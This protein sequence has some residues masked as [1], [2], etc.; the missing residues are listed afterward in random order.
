MPQQHQ[1][2]ERHWQLLVHPQ[3]QELQ[4]PVQRS[5]LLLQR[6]VTRL[7]GAMEAQDWRAQEAS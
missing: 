4:L 2:E 1:Q 5:Q 7:Q 3:S 6:R